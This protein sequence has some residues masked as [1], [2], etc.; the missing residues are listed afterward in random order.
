[1]TPSILPS[2]NIAPALIPAEVEICTEN[3][4]FKVFEQKSQS[5]LKY[6]GY[7]EVYYE[8]RSVGSIT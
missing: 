2:K 7:H 8:I 6:S 5:V 3:E 4:N 1:M